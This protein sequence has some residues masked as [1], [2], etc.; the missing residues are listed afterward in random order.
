MRVVVPI[1]MLCLCSARSVTL[2]NWNARGAQCSIAF[3]GDSLTV[4]QNITGP[5]NTSVQAKLG[6]GGTGY[7]SAWNGGVVHVAHTATGFGRTGTWTDAEPTNGAS[8][9]ASFST[10]TATPSII[11]VTSSVTAF[12][13]HYLVQSGGGSFQYSVD[14]GAPVSVSTSGSAAMG[15]ATNSGLALGSHYI[16]MQ[17]TAAG[18]TGV[19]ICGVDCSASAGFRLHNLGFSGTTASSWTDS[20]IN[21]NLFQ[22]SL[23]TISPQV[24]MVLLGVNDCNGNVV[25]DTYSNQLYSLVLRIKSAATNSDV[26]LV[27]PADIGVATTYP[28]SQYNTRIASIASLLGCVYVDAFDAWGAYGNNHTIGWQENTTHPNATGG[29]VIAGYIYGALFPSTATSMNGSV[30][31]R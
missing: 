5:L 31:M 12:V 9:S 2:T 15:Y 6:N 26:M 16:Q 25:P 8:I 18:S 29:G 30:I 27:S 13:V 4:G 21:T 3:I 28:M 1:L 19:G 14:G 11:S 17:I 20:A 10:D 24:V 23:Y 22:S 7:C